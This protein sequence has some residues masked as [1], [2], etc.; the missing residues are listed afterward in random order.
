MFAQAFERKLLLNTY[1][2]LVLKEFI[3]H[4]GALEMLPDMVQKL[5]LPTYMVFGILFFIITFISGSSG[6]IAVGA[7]LAFAALPVT[8][9]LVVF[10][11]SIVHASSQMGLT[12]PCLVVAAEYYEITLGDM[13]KKTLPYALAFCA[14]VT[15]YYNLWVMFL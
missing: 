13:V 4:T 5:P 12:H 10:L 15:V 6:A 14:M 3:S 11:M 9:P 8:T 7:P 1:M 2:V